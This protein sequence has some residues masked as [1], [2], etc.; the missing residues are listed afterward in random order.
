MQNTIAD[1][2]RPQQARFDYYTPVTR[3]ALKQPPYNIPY[4]ETH[5]KRLRDRD[6]F[7]PPHQLSPNR[8]AWFHG[9]LMEWLRTRP[10][11]PKTARVGGRNARPAPAEKQAPAPRNTKLA[12]NRRAV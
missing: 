11:Q 3:R 5:L 9:E 12:K 7:P 6:E 1:E 4:S 10:T 8:I 2:P